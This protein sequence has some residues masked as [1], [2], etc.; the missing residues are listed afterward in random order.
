VVGAPHIDVVPAVVA[1]SES[2]GGRSCSWRRGQPRGGG[3]G[4]LGG[5]AGLGGADDSLPPLLP[6][7]MGIGVGDI[8]GGSVDWGDHFFRR[9]WSA[10]LGWLGGFRSIF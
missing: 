9:R 5:A 1:G 4:A 7:V 2:T 10:G 6:I 8:F 3:S